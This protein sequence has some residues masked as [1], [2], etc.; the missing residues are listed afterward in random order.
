MEMLLI[1]GGKKF[2]KIILVITSILEEF[3]GKINQ[4]KNEDKYMYHKKQRNE[5][6]CI[7]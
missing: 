4:R 3:E 1:Y 6:I 2:N 7:V 5:L